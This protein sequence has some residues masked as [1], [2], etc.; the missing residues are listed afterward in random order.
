VG[1]ES[2]AI[3]Q[4]GGGWSWPYPDLRIA[5]HTGIKLGANS[6][7]QGIRFYTDYD[8]SSQVMSVNNG[9]DPLGGG[10]VYVN[11][12]LQAGGSLRAPIFYDSNDTTYY[13]D[14]AATTALRTVGDWRANSHDWSGE[15]SGKMQYHAGH[16]YI[17]SSSLFIFRNAG[18]AN[19][20]QCDSSGNVTFSGNVTAYSD[21]RLKSNV[22][23]LDSAAKY[24]SVIDAKRFTWNADGRADIGF[25]A[26]DV[27]E[28]GL[29]EFVLETGG[30]DPNTETHGETVKSLDYGR[31][32]AVLWQAVKEQQSQIEAAVAEI[33]SLKERLQ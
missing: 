13:T 23:T 16:W 19:V 18:G 24:L 28:A 9:S 7:Y 11:S 21:R 1:T 31:M 29:P 20:M 27:E 25:I 6:S 10:N 17:Q 14:P 15:F 32:V 26:Q 3:Y 12:A 4:E 33:K 5:F 30:Y 22:V 8:M 2:Y